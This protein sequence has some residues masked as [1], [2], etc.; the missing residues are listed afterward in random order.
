VLLFTYPLFIISLFFILNIF[1]LPT[2]IILVILVSLPIMG[3]RVQ[4]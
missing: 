4:E 1:H 2:T 3:K